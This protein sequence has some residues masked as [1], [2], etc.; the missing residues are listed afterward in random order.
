[1]AGSFQTISFISTTGFGQ[2]DNSVWPAMANALLIFAAFHC[3]CSGSTTGGLKADRVLIS[4]KAL[5]ND[6]NKRLHPHSMFRTK[7]GGHVVSEEL[8]SSVFLYIVIYFAIVVISLIAL[9]LCGVELSEA[10]SGSV[11]SLGNVGPGTGALGTMGNYSAQ[12]IAAKII[13]TLD[14][15]LGRVEIFPL[16]IVISMFFSRRDD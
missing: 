4:F 5:A 8:V 7:V 2:S 16:M 9:L 15:F 3:G 11:A 14:M 12:P 6:T 1:M 10:F 13:Y